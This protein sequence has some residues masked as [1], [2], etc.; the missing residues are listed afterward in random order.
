L[1]FIGMGQEYEDQIPFDAK[2]MINN[3]FDNK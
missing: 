1:L 3:I 2:W